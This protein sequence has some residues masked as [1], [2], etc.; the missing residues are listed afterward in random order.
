M[1]AYAHAETRG[2]CQIS[3]SN[4]SPPY[5]LRQGLSLK[6]KLTLS[7][8]SE[9]LSL[10]PNAAQCW[11]Q[12]CQVSDLGYSDLHSKR[13]PQSAVPQPT[14]LCSPLHSPVT[15]NSI[16]HFGFFTV[17]SIPSQIFQFFPLLN[18]SRSRRGSCF[19]YLSGCLVLFQYCYYG[20]GF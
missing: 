2:R 16:Y 17:C 18:I 11:A 1:W 14:S 3:F 5:L 4:P 19:C 12:Q 20:F 7:P 13:L 9:A 15:R 6:L 10:L 8:S